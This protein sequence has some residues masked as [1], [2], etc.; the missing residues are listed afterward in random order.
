MI[1]TQ[2]KKRRISLFNLNLNE[3]LPVQDICLGLILSSLLINMLALVFPLSLLQIYDRI[4]PNQATQTLFYL[5]SAVSIAIILEMIL[6]LAR[7]YVSAWGDAKLGYKTSTKAYAHL[8]NAKLNAFEKIGSGVHLDRMNAL[9]RVK[10]FYG[11]QAI[12]T[13]IDL[14]FV[15]VYLIMIFMINPVMILIPIAMQALIVVIAIAKRSTLHDTLAFRSHTNE[16]KLNYIVEVLSGIHT[17]KSQGMEQVM[18]RRYER[19]QKSSAIDDFEFAQKNASFHTLGQHVSGLNLILVVTIGALLAIN[20]H[21]TPGGVAA[22]ILL[23]SRS[24]LPFVKFVGLWSKLQ[25]IRIANDKYNAIMSMPTESQ[26]HTSTLTIEQGDIKLVD[27]CFQF[28]DDQ[29]VIFEHAYMHIKPGDVVHVDSQGSAGKSVL[30]LLLSGALTPTKGKILIDDNDLHDY[31]QAL[32]GHQIAYI[33]QDAKLFQGSIIENLTLFRDEYVEKAKAMAKLLDLD[34]CIEQMPQGYQ[35]QV[36]QGSEDF[37]SK[38][39]KQRILII[40]SL[41]DS[42]KIVMFDEANSAMDIASDNK[43]KALLSQMAGQTTLLMVTHRPSLV[44][45]CNKKIMIQNKQVV[46]QAHATT[47]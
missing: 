23:S 43:L 17:I 40:R 38:G 14:P 26:N 20:N 6:K 47:G 4:I 31:P 13:L 34:H 46:E 30:F 7:H 21:M 45:L 5:M 2:A 41:I 12:T 11:G 27:L 3:W 8:M 15:A 19:L 44:A 33:P 10:D 24:M 35:T 25:S 9:N 36:A 18:L 39:I 29:Q 28:D 37:I 42:P 32:L 1:Q 16:K 22:C